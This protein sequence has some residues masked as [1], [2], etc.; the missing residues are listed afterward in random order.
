MISTE[1]AFDALPSV[2]TIYDKLDIDG[3]R[4]KIAQEN[5]EKSLNAEAVGID[6]IK[7]IL[8]NTPKVKEEAFSIVAIFED[9]TVEEIKT[10]SFGKTFMAI[11][12]IFADKELMGFFKQAI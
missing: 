12:T 3:Y 6:L 8:T 5:N 4:K 9:K 1:K 10:Q 2:V 7:Y 11:K